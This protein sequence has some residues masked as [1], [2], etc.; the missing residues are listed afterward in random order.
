M[1][2]ALPSRHLDRAMERRLHRFFGDR[3]GDLIL[4][5]APLYEQ[6]A[7]G[8]TGAGGGPDDVYALPSGDELVAGCRWH[9]CT[10]K[11]AV[12]VSR[13][14]VV[15]SVGIISHHCRYD[16]GPVQAGRKRRGT[17]C[18]HDPHLTVF[19]PYG[20]RQTLA[21][22]ILNWARSIPETRA[23]SHEVVQIGP[24]PGRHGEHP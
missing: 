5:D 20:S 22:P 7:E 14:G 23:V 16:A 2:E 6:A 11:T 12:V 13:T 10:E 15:R 9:S 4:P 18:D 8:L 17:T 3:R 21:E 1:L 24:A 19:V